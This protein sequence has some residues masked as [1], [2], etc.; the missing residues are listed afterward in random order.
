MATKGSRT[1]V[2]GLIKNPLTFYALAI[3]IV[4]AI[5]GLVVATSRMSEQYKFYSI[6]IMAGLF[7]VVVVAVTIITIVYPDHLYEPIVQK[8]SKSTLISR[9]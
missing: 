2:L 6:C 1:K 5:F 8:K 4:E 9:R 7:V 3:S